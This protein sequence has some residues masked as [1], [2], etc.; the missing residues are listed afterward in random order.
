MASLSQTVTLIMELW[1]A[2]LSMVIFVSVFVKRHFD[3]KG[4][5][6]LMAVV[7][8]CALL[9]VCDGAARYLRGSTLPWAGTAIRISQFL[10]FFFIFLILPL[11]AEYL[12]HIILKAVPGLK[13][14]LWPYL[15]WFFFL[16]SLV[17]VTVNLF[18]PFI[19]IIDDANN[20]SRLDFG[21]LPG[22]ILLAGFVSSFG[23]SLSYISSLKKFERLAVIS[24]LL[25]P[26]V[27]AGIQTFLPDFQFGYLASII[28]LFVIYISFEVEYHEHNLERERLAAEE[29]VRLFSRQ[30]QP[31]F[32]FNTLSVIRYLCRTSPEQAAE[33]ID[34]FSGYLRSSTDFMTEEKCIPLQSELDLL[35]HYF[36]LQRK[37]FGDK[38]SYET[39]IQDDDF[40]I[41][42]FCL[43]TLAENSINHGIRAK[44]GQN[45]KVSVR[46]YF[47]D[48]A[49]NIEIEDDGA[50]FDPA[51]LE[52]PAFQKLH[53]GIKNTQERLKLMCGGDMSIESEKDKGTRVR[54]RIPER[55]VK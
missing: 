21:M 33:A 19:Y 37:R 6:R 3:K 18:K 43:Q 8:C 32:M 15:E 20:Y 12:T 7:L 13:G 27:Y 38:I 41:P 28:C 25:L 52:D 30:I 55:L 40:D 16:I 31:H 26:I 10:V 5:H 2:F 46:T 34:E 45:G 39:D 29:R 47:K 4:A 42:P 11:S 53:V 36:Y 48:G 23:V 54:I 1:G 50:G 35:E 24:Y 44:S 17:L 22:I 49:H 51:L 9:L 14:L